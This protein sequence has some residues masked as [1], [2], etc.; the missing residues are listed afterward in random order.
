[1]KLK[2]SILTILLTSTAA[3]S[4]VEFTGAIG[5]Y[6]I[7]LELDGSEDRLVG[8][9]RYAGRDAWIELAGDAY[10]TDALQLEE[11]VADSVTGQFYLENHDQRLEGY[12][13]NET[14]DFEVQL[15]PVKG[16]IDELLKIAPLL[17]VSEAPTGQYEVSHHWVNSF[18]APN[19][20]IGF[21]GGTVN[22]VAIEP[23]QP[24][25]ILVDFNFIVGPTYHS[26][27]FRGFATL[28][29]DGVY[30]HDEVLPYGETKCR[31]V[32]RFIGKQLS[33]D[34]EGNGHACQFG[35][36]AHANF[37]LT[38]ISDTAEFRAPW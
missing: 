16:A 13:V 4:P 12:W 26:A 36:R 21:N 6:Q 18:F 35:A 2:V 31:L 7:E 19:Y 30:V 20:E 29:E 9:Y 22:V 15:T 11:R 33:I 32:F 14:T 17:D 38:K 10:G 27:W 28:T 3:A 34:D 23:G 25:Q 5:P 37:T 8:R 1:M 24:N